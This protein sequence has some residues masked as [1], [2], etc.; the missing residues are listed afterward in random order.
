MADLSDRALRRKSFGKDEWLSD[1][2]SRGAGR[3]VAKLTQSELSFYF[4]YFQG[5]RKRFLPVGPYD[6]KGERGK[7]R[8][9]ASL[10]RRNTRPKTP[11]ALRSSRCSTPTAAT[12]SVRAKWLRPTCG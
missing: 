7:T 2:G 1:G 8:A 5:D 6:L 11:S 12:L 10:K 4:L 3:L 9:G